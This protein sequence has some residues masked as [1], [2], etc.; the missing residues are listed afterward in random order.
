LHARRQGNASGGVRKGD[1]HHHALVLAAD[2]F[3]RHHPLAPQPE[4]PRE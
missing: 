1:V 4:Q 3:Y 2:E